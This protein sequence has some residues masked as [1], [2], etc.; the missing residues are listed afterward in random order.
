MQTAD[1]AE[2]NIRCIAELFPSCVTETKDYSV[3]VCLDSEDSAL[4]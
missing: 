1:A 3:S 2:L 4:M